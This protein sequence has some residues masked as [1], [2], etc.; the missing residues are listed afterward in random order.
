MDNAIVI[1]ERQTT[2]ERLNWLADKLGVE[3]RDAIFDVGVGVTTNDEV[4]VL[5]S[6]CNAA[7]AQTV[8]REI[9]YMREEN[10]QITLLLA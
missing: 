9:A 7:V 2:R 5:A 1:Y 3:H 6:G 8:G 10:D 4:N